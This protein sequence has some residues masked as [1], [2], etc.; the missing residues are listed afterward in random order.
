MTPLDEKEAKARV[1]YVLHEQGY[2]YFNI[3]RLTWVE[4]KDLFMGGKL[5]EKER[6][7]R[8]K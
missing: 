5:V 4:I 3:P 8:N 6:A 2:N 1:T 7:Q